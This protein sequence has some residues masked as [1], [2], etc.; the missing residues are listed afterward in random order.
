VRRLAILGSTGSIGQS[1]LAV[2]DAH[3]SRLK[4]VSLA[5]GDNADLLAE[6]VQRYR[7]NVAALATAEGMD[8][9]RAT[10][11]ADGSVTLVGG[12][13]GLIAA[14]T[15]PDADI[16]I[17][18]SAG[19]AALEAVLAAIDAGKM[20][21]IAN[22]EIL[23]MAGAL[24]TDAARRKGVSILPIDSEHN[25]VHQCLHGRA[26]SELRRLILT[27]SG[28][29][30]RCFSAEELERV[31]PSQALKH[32]T[33][34]M[35][36]KITI[37]SA[38]LMNK[39]L[40]VIEAHWLFDVSADQID[41]LIHPQ[42]I[43]HSLVELGDGSVIAQLGV[44]DMRLPIQYACSYPE[45]WEALLP[46]LDLARAGVLE[47]FPPEYDRFPCLKLAY[48]A[49]RTGGTLPVVLNAANEIAVE[50]FL[51]GKLAF[52]SIPV[53][54]EQAMNGHTVESVSTLE[55]VRRV[56]RWAR[57]YARDRAGDLQSSSLVLGDSD[58]APSR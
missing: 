23:V 18:A 4:V 14:A 7:P 13:D 54:I 45:R 22:K 2:V 11:G 32:P 8:R 42:S 12:A 3:P 6:Q 52:M 31:S 48:R 19:T 39:G 26:R 1:A 58:G 47:F 29:P 38:T 46:S 10:R 28:G 21:A 56:D 50:A 51:D 53:V 16:V 55:I 57:T 27:A 30:F 49:L 41:V 40:E 9:L 37:D 43:V 24:V 35:G 5:A 36:R 25:A 33:W 17:C 20:I 44:T 34:K 15:C